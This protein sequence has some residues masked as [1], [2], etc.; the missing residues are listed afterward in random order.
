MIMVINMKKTI[1]YIITIIT[2]ICLVVISINYYVIK[3]T[4]KQIIHINDITNINDI[5]CILVLGCQVKANGSL[6][7][8][9]QDRLDTAI[10]IYNNTHHK[11]LMS[12]DHG[13][14]QYDE[15]NA[16]KAYAISHN[17][18]SK[19]VF[20]DHAGFSTYESIYRAKAIFDADT[21]IIVTQKYH[22]YRALYIANQL[23]LNAYG[24]CCEDILYAN[25]IQREIR[26]I[27]ARNKDVVQCLL[28]LKPTYL[29][30]YID[31]SGDGNITNDK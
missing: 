26:E 28:K 8:M 19:D 21:I 15:V 3:S 11:L 13:Q 25:Q 5:D 9:L 14:E 18:D 20:M 4:T 2:I 31:I 7:L 23:G 27:L 29:G 17:I 12:G 22:M 10:N 1:K 6:S 16:M 30:E 24:V